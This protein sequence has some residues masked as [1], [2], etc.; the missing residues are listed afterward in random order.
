VTPLRLVAACCALSWLIVPGFAVPDLLV[1]WDSDWPVVLEAGWG[2]FCGVLVAG[3]FAVVAV[4]PRRC[5]PALAQL[6]LAA[7]ALTVSAAVAAESPRLRLA[8]LLAAQ[9][10]VATA[11]ARSLPGRERL[12]PVTGRPSVALL[13]LALTGAGPWTAY[14]VA[15]WRAARADAPVDI[16]LGIDHFAVQG[17][18]AI[19]LPT[20]ALLAAAWPR[21]R[22]QLGLATGGAAGYLGLVSLAWPGA[23][24]GHGPGW[25]MLMIAWGLLVAANGVPLRR[26]LG[27]EGAR[28]AQRRGRAP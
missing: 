23:D 25:S 4:R 7:A 5:A 16:T 13:V 12:R 9:A 11:L 8:G 10:A 3:A 1:T 24:A 2:V 21:G 14:A 20:V 6:W 18:L 28:T 17:A 15:M 22:A 26:V 19:T 27:P